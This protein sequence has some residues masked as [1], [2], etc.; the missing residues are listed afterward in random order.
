MH[1]ILPPTALLEIDFQ[2]WII[3]SVAGGSAVHRAASVRAELR[4][5]GARVFCTRY[6]S[7]DAADTL[8]ADPAGYGASFHPELTPAAG[9]IVL[10]KYHRDVFDNP[11]VDTNLELLGIT[12]VVVT[13]IATDHGVELAARA[14]RRRG[15]RTSVVADA[16]AGTSTEAHE[17]ALDSLA[18][19][20]ITVIRDRQTLRWSALQRLASQS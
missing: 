3:E 17:R 12:Q 13:G 16:C 20:G 10:S 5:A 14:A 18:E 8:R 4:R 1:P 6:L 19:A 7:L 15:Y 9:D 11:D 2:H